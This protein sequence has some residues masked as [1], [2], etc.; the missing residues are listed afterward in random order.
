VNQDKPVFGAA[1]VA[2]LSS[3]GKLMEKGQVPCATIRC[4]YEDLKRALK[5]HNK[6]GLQWSSYSTWMVNDTGLSPPDDVQ[7]PH[8]GAL[9]KASDHHAIDTSAGR[10]TSW[11]TDVSKGFE[12]ATGLFCINRSEDPS[13]DTPGTHTHRALSS[14]SKSLIST[15]S[16]FVA[17]WSI[18]P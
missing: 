14:S 17:S 12:H 9:N 11:A 5:V 7:K 6:V 16:G 18:Y 15:N 4:R 3:I 1:L 8:L 10:G 13:E 2:L